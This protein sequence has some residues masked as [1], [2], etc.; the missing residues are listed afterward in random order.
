MRLEKGP[1]KEPIV[2]LGSGL[3]L[4]EGIA[5]DWITKVIY[6]VDSRLHT[7]EVCQVDGRNRVILLN[8]NITQPRGIVLDPSPE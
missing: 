5:Y 6:F 1:E 4:V 7:L 2:V 8:S 3:D